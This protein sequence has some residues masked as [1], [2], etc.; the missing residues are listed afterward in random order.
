MSKLCSASHTEEDIQ[1]MRH[2]FIWGKPSL[3]RLEIKYRVCTQNVW[4]L[5][6]SSEI[7]I[8]NLCELC[9]FKI[10]CRVN[11]F[12]VHFIWTEMWYHTPSSH[13]QQH[14]QAR[15]SRLK[16]RWKQSY[17]QVFITYK[18]ETLDASILASIAHLNEIY[19]LEINL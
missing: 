5:S 11:A 15:G 2:E 19:S 4:S 16:I 18:Q 10:G 13:L 7:Q 8:I 12:F 6:P 14:P 9:S 17:S 1:N 3:I